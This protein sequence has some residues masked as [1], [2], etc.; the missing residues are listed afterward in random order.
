MGLDSTNSNPVRI[1]FLTSAEAKKDLMPN[2]NPGNVEKI[3]WAL[4]ILLIAL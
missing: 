4:V 1:I 2:S 3:E